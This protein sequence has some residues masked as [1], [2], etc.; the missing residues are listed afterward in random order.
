[1][2]NSLCVDRHLQLEREATATNLQSGRI[3]LQRCHASLGSIPGSANAQFLRFLLELFGDLLRMCEVSFR[4]ERCGANV[5]GG[6]CYERDVELQQPMSIAVGAVKCSRTCG[7][8]WPAVRVSM[9]RV[10]K[11]EMYWTKTSGH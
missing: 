4:E 11:G 10:S 1:M 5:G 8:T 6:I 3:S 7:R 9:R 2:S